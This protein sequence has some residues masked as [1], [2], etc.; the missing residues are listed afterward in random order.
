MLCEL[1]G[2]NVSGKAIVARY[3]NLTSNELLVVEWDATCHATGFE[4]FEKAVLS[5]GG[6]TAKKVVDASG[7]PLIEGMYIGTDANLLSTPQTH[8]V[9]CFICICEKRT[10]IDLAYNSYAAKSMLSRPR[11]FSAGRRPSLM[12]SLCQSRRGSG[13][14]LGHG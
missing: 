1:Q 13:T 3:S 10:F 6:A 12:P 4:L 7:E 14:S 9:R 8:E 2:T 5:D 11:I